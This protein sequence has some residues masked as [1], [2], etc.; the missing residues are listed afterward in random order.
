MHLSKCS[1]N[2]YLA[3]L[4]VVLHFLLGGKSQKVRRHPVVILLSLL[5]LLL[6][7]GMS[8]AAHRTIW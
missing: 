8:M 5:F 7:A 3:D 6:L 1:N 4:R 2:Q